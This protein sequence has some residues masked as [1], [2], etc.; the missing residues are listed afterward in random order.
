MTVLADGQM[1]YRGLLMGVDTPYGLRSVSGLDGVEVRI[2]DRPIPRGHGSIPVAS[3]AAARTPVIEFVVHHDPFETL[4]E[5]LAPLYDVLTP[6]DAPQPLEWK[7]EGRPQRRVY[8]VPH[9]VPADQ[10]ART[11]EIVTYPKVA[12]WCP[13]PRIYGSDEQAI[14]VPLYDATGGGVDFPLDFPVDFPAGAQVEAVVTNDGNTDAYP[15]LRFDGPA[16]EVAL[17]NVTTGQ[18]ITFTTT[19]TAGQI[20]T[21]DGNAH[22][23]STGGLVVAVDGAGRLSAWA[24]P[25][26]PFILPPGTSVLRFTADDPAAQAS[27]TWRSTWIT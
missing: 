26:E 24:A 9:I 16:G 27:L 4:G 6:V 14:V 10:Q 22:A 19:I 25:Y 8:A 2:P 12:F 20:L 15:L 13:D 7:R 5:R 23:A 3:Y 18:T 21:F 11:A 17:T 1:S